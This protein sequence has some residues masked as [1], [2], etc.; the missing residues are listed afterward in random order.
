MALTPNSDIRLMKVPIEIDN[1]NQ[2]TFSDIE[3]Q[4]DYFMSLDAIEI[5]HC[6]YQRKDNVMFFPAH[7]DSIIEYNYIMYKNNNYSNKWFY[8]FVTDKKYQSNGMTELTIKTDVFQTWQFD[9]IYKK[10]FVEREIVNTADD[11]VGNNTIPEGLQLGEYISN[12]KSQWINSVGHNPLYNNRNMAIVVGAT[13]LP[14]GTIPRKYA[15]E[16]KLT[17]YIQD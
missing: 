13:S 11:I 6:Q 2:L 10:M 16:L 17:E 1:K 9:I 15:T 3:A 4:E 14:D 7:I 12:K 8:A 5:D